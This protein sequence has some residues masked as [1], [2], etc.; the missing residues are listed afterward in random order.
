[1]VRWISVGRMEDA[2]WLVWLALVFLYVSKVLDLVEDSAR[3]CL[4]MQLVRT[5]DLVQP[6]PASSRDSRVHRSTNFVD[7]LHGEKSVVSTHQ[8]VAD[9]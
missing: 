7:G 9:G 2:K 1:M 8:K 6:R 4:V 3:L 5:S